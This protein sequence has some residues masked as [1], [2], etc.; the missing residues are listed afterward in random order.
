M[1]NLFPNLPTFTGF[2]RPCRVEANIYDLEYEGEI[3]AGLN[4]TF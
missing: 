3:P 2:N 1:S 4:G